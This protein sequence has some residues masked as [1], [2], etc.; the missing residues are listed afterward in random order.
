MPFSLPC[1]RFVC[2]RSSKIAVQIFVKMIRNNSLARKCEP[3][4]LKTD[5]RWCANEANSAA[6]NQSNSHWVNGRPK[7]RNKSK[8]SGSR[9]RK[10]GWKRHFY[11]RTECNANWTVG[12]C[13]RARILNC[14]DK[15]YLLNCM[16]RYGVNFGKLQST[17]SM[18]IICFFSSFARCQQWTRH[19]Q[20]M[21]QTKP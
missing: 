20:R 1:L 14:S 6:R 4:T 2:L 15:Q 13:E 10:S 8:S 3:R 16:T 19:T 21:H 12:E 7:W 17:G 18:E 11:I 5:R 9:A